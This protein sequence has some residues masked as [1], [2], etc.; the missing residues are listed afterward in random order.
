MRCGEM[1]LLC[2]EKGSKQKGE[3]AERSMLGKTDTNHTAVEIHR[4][5]P[6]NAFQKLRSSLTVEKC[7]LSH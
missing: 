7:S 6:L 4:Q 2:L 5:S 1:R 3:Q